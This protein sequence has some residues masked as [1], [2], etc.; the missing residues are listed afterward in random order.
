MEKAEFIA[1]FNRH[2]RATNALGIQ[3][4]DMGQGCATATL[5]HSDCSKNF[6]GALHGG[7]LATLADITAGCCLYYRQRL[8][9]TLDSSI[10]YLRGVREGVV[11]ARAKEVHA[12][13]HIAV[14]QVDITDKDGN[15]CCVASVS[16]Y[17]TDKVLDVSDLLP[18]AAN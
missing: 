6:M 13:G 14:M 15:L 2:D 1:Y 18:S 12:G 3:L 8:C 4:V 16:M 11:T 9:V 10:R 17:L 7:A 5:T